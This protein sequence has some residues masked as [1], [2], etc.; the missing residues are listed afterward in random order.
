[1]FA[2]YR[3][4]RLQRSAGLI[5]M[6]SCRRDA[7]CAQREAET[8]TS[9]LSPPAGGRRRRWRRRDDEFCFKDG[10]LR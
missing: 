8:E 3:V 1:L 9:S 10:S 6:V 2:R 7:V 5:R 4:F